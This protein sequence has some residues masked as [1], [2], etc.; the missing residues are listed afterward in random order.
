MY[1]FNHENKF[2]YRPSF[3]L[4]LDKILVIEL[5]SEVLCEERTITLLGDYDSSCSIK[6]KRK[7]KSCVLVLNP[8]PV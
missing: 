4:R 5:V 7:Y 6:D 3:W 8:K 2:Q 1:G